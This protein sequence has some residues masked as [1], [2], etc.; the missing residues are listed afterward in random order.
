[1]Y[2]PSHFVEERL[3]VLHRWMRENSF[4]TVVSV[5]DGAPFATHLPVL[6]DAS[7]GESGTLRAHMA[8]ANPH[9][10][11]FDGEA[12]T[13]VIFQ[14]PHGYITPSWYEPDRAVP[15]WNY[16]AV[17]A[18]GRP[19]VFQ[20]E[21]ALELLHDQVSLY[22]SGFEKPWDMATQPPGYIEGMASG[23]VAFEVEIAR[24]EGK[25]KLSQNRPAD[26]DRVIAELQSRGN[27][28]L[29]AAMRACPEG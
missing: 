7:R 20:G 12:E 15:T 21:A 19:R 8:K 27:G 16:T 24:L 18:Y 5:V 14:G 10:H 4:A 22:E 9:W 26:R 2:T 6:L 11:A 29:A 1:M 28:A 25:G 23:I 13:L 17:H 3:P